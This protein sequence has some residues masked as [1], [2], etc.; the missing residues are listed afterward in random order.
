VAPVKRALVYLWCYQR[1]RHHQKRPRTP[2][3]PQRMLLVMPVSSSSL[4]FL[5]MVQTDLTVLCLLEA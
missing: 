2:R 1:K 4:L 5:D 3:I